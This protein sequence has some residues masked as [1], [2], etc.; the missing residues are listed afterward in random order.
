MSVCNIFNE[1]NSSGGTFLTFSQYTEDLTRELSD[2]QGYHISPSKFI[3]LNIDYKDFDNTSLP[4]MLQNYYENCCAFFKD[5]LG[6]DWSPNV[7]KSLL[8]NTLVEQ[9]LLTLYDEKNK[10]LCE[11]SYIGDINMVS[12]NTVDGLS[13]NEL[14]CYIP[15]D[16]KKA[17]Y[18]ITKTDEG[19]EF[20]YNENYI[21][22]YS[23]SDEPPLSGKLSYSTR[24]TYNA[25][26]NIEKFINNKNNNSIINT[27][28]NFTFNTII[29][30][31]NIYSINS[32]GDM[33]ATFTNIPM[34]IYFTGP[35]KNNEMINA[36]TKYVSSEDVFGSGTSY[37]LKICTR[38]T[39]SPVGSKIVG[40][41]VS[42]ENTSTS[43]VM[44]EMS[45]T[46]NSIN[47]M[48]AN[49]ATN[50]ELLKT[51]LATFKNDRTNVPYIKTINGDNYWFINGRNTGILSNNK[52]YTNTEVDTGIDD[53]DKTLI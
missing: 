12:S 32:N 48:I 34:G 30:L 53:F 22:G 41:N 14:F 52:H 18:K 26:Y 21:K 46:L 42:T 24:Y 27:T 5:T 40:V 38:F 15:N 17:N 37:G 11:I 8:I 44:S 7:A 28:D 36:V 45:K 31:Y 4:Q 6:N 25:E 43:L 2:P 35:I 3:A 19:Q 16:A 47:K 10:K 20:E 9:N 13:Y 51:S 1:L 49:N 23:N 29:V 50:L 33:S 39:A